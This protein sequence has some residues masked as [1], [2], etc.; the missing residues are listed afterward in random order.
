MTLEQ[1]AELLAISA[2]IAW[3]NTLCSGRPPNVQMYYE[4][5]G[6][7]NVGDLVVETTTS[8]RGVSALDRVGRLISV[9][10]ET[11]EVEGWDISVDGPYPTYL[12]YTIETLDGREFGWTNCNFVVIPEDPFNHQAKVKV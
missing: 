9:R 2:Y 6:K 4:R 7:P 5:M 11:K 8:K 12:V 10:E 1:V 3:T